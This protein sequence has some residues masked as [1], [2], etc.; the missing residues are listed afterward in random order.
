VESGTDRSHRNAKGDRAFVVRQVKAGVEKE[1]VSVLVANRS[2][3][4]TKIGSA[5]S[6]RLDN[7]LRVAHI[8]REETSDG[9]QTASPA[10]RLFAEELDRNPEQSRPRVLA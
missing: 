6:D 2:E 9:V 4:L 1:Q 5:V 3:R 7:R 10:P 8:L